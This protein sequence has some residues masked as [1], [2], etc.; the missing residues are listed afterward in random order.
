MRWPFRLGLF[1]LLLAPAGPSFATSPPT[2]AAVEAPFCAAPGSRHCATP[3]GRPVHFW[4]GH[5]VHAGDGDRYTG[6]VMLLPGTRDLP[7]EAGTR[8]LAVAEFRRR[9]SAWQL[10]DRSGPVN[11]MKSIAW[12]VQARTYVPTRKQS[13]D[14]VLAVPTA[15]VRDGKRLHA[16]QLLR[17]DAGGWAYGGSVPAAID[18]LRSCPHGVPADKDDPDACDTIH[19][20]L[21]FDGPAVDGWPE[22]VVGVD[23][24]SRR[25]GQPLTTFDWELHHYKYDPAAQGYMPRP[26]Q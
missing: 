15:E 10:V 5:A 23:L 25:N 19:G 14:E 21:L 11:R 12:T 8:L 16:Y 20:S 18:D 6:F 2:P 1:C 4:W 26:A 22:V 7:D 17:H 24:L 13:G 9:G 3:E